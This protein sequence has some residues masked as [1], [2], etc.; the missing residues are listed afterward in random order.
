MHLS[1]IFL[2]LS[3]IFGSKV[4]IPPGGLPTGGLQT[5]GVCI[6]GVCP[7]PCTIPLPCMPSCQW[8]LLNPPGL[9]RGSAWGGASASRGV[10]LRGICIQGVC[11]TPPGLPQGLPTGGLGRPP[12]PV[13]RM[14]D[15][16][17]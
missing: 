6:Q 17:V 2:H 14:T 3:A 13:N 5:W 8:G 7:L 12:P 1:Y 15:R 10:C 11:P 4:K 9:P 16:Q